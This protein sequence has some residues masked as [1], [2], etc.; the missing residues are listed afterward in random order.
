MVKFLVCLTCSNDLST[1]V[2]RSDVGGTPEEHA[3]Q[4]LRLFADK[5]APESGQGRSPD[6]DH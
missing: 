3:E 5:R 4:V 6:L 1:V 2:A